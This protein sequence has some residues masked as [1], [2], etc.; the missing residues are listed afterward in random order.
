MK[1]RQFLIQGSLTATG[2]VFINSLPSFAGPFFDELKPQT[3]LYQLFKNPDA[4]YRPYVRWWWNGDKIE[5]S[6]L[7]RELRIL[8][9]AGIGGV[10]INP[11]SF[12]KRTDDMGIPSVDWLSDEWIELLR[13]TLEEA[14]S[15][16]MFCDLLLGTGFP[17]GADFLEGEERSQVVVIGVIKMEGPFETEISSFDLFKVADPAITNPYSGRTMELLE[18][19]LVPDPMNSL[20][21]VIDLSDQIKNGIIKVS[22]PKG[23]YAVYGLV[24]VEGFMKVIQGAPGGMGPVLN[25]FNGEA[26]QKYMN[27]ISGSIQNKIG[28]LAPYLRSFFVDSLET[29]GANWNSDM[30]SEFQKRRG[31]DLYPYLPFILF[32]IA[33]MGNTFDNTYPVEYAPEFDSML[34]RM[35][36]DF[37]YTKAELFH[38]RFVHNYAKWCTENKVKSRAQ[39]YG[40][41]YFPLEGSFEIDIP[42]CET[43]LKYGIGKDI[44]ESD[45]TK[46]P[47]HL[48]QGNTMINK[49]VSSAAHLKN[50]R[51][52]SSEELTNTDMVFNATFEIFKI[53]GDQSTISGVTQPVFHGFN[54]SPKEAPFP[55]WITYGC[56]F[57]EKNNFWPYFKH[58]TD[59]RSR[60]SALLQQATMFA[61]IALLAPFPD[62]WSIYGA[63]NEPF[64]T[65][66]YPAYQMLIWE[67]IHQN[68]NA[69]DYVS[70]SVLNDS[71][72]KDGFIKYGKRKYHT[73]FLIEIKSITTS[74][75]KKLHD[76]V[77][78]GGRIICVEAFPEKSLGWKD[79]EKNDLAV[80]NWVN[81]M[82][83]YP[84]RFIFL[85]KPE[86]DFIQWYQRIQEAYKIT[87]YVKI[88]SPKKFVSQ[89][90]YQAENAEIIMFTNSSDEQSYDLN[91]GFENQITRRKQAWLW[92]AVTG[93]R[94]RL[95]I[96]NGNLNI[97]LRPAEAKIVVFDKEKKGKEW[98]ELPLSLPSAKILNNKWQVKFEHTDGTESTDEFSTLSDLK[99]IEKYRFFSGNVIYKNSF[100]ADDKN[101]TNYLNLGKV[102]GIS[103]VTIN[104][105]NAGVQWYGARVLEI[106]DLLKTGENSIEIKVVTV[107][108]NYMKTL[109]DNPVAQYW[110]NEKRKDQPILSMGLVGPVSI[111]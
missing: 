105:K 79:Y 90:R 106:G 76:F 93:E 34:Q 66:V 12:P 111:Y 21:Q 1:R 110:T 5:K 88:K 72:M 58:Y 33:G 32:K 4:S 96:D 70:E 2:L 104:G 27:H 74:T 73:L 97:S 64:P 51:L 56:Y 78:N 38:E 40:R 52:V 44:P 77:A 11:I 55:G 59:Y 91:L 20:D 71:E 94:F 36:Y 84:D 43:W 87:P 109:K 65:L 46:Y 29:E 3:N 108:G 45:F 23:K 61:D 100:I 95:K 62:M 54:Y 18:V 68:G 67:A 89:V 19:K 31:Y 86:N 49:L 85:N 41:G 57:N 8:K 30:M 82:K 39:A 35:R 7:A 10:E 75:A 83:A 9:E 22:V 69:C 48:G 103:D 107:M 80:K 81:K 24:K 63:Q 6:E 98:K 15:L 53:A 101:K 60:L 25:H 37:E 50:K 26:V 28:P 47:W 16:G 17:C 92:D 14:K 42:E 102:Y 99:D 13:F